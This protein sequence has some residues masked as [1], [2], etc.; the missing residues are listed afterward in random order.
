MATASLATMELDA[1]RLADQ[2]NTT[3]RFPQTEVWRYIN[4]GIAEWWDLVMEAGGWAWI[5]QKATLS[6]SAGTTQY[7]LLSAGAGLDVLKIDR[8]FLSGYEEPLEEMYPNDEGVW[9]EA[10]R[11]R[12]TVYQLRK[13]YIDF[14]ATPDTS[15]TALLRYYSK[16]TVLTAGT[17]T[18]DAING[19]G[20]EYA[21]TYAARKMCVK[22]GETEEGQVLLQQL[23]SL[24]ARIRAAA[25]TRNKGAPKRVQD[26]RGLPSI[27]GQI[28][29]PGR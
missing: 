17:D 12:P 22:D 4:Q 14:Y 2:E 18:L 8:I 3:S 25:K 23:A 24:Q 28:W 19:W 9:L 15:Y 21:A 26:V 1:R 10:E 20:D 5:G 7:A 11:A 6:L 29:R 13:D 16:P 27:R